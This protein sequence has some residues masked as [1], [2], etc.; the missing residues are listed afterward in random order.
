MMTLGSVPK[1]TPSAV[2]RGS[3]VRRHDLDWL[4]ILAVLLLIPFH[5]ARVFDTFEAFYVKNGHAAASCPGA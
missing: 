1:G 4:R 5:S 3:A 2:A